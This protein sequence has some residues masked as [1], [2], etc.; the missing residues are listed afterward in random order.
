MNEKPVSDTKNLKSLGAVKTDYAKDL[1]YNPDV[2]E[3]FDAPGDNLIVKFTTNEFTSLCPRTHQPD[4][5]ANITLIYAPISHCVES[6][7]L[8]QYYMGYRNR[9]DFG[10]TIAC[11]IRDD[12]VKLL[13]P[14]WL[15]V[16]VELKPRGGIGWTSFADFGQ[17]K[18]EGVNGDQQNI[19]IL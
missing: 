8:K 3:K 7:S 14:M 15:R 10:E 19:R 5:G 1:E 16:I 17:V 2:L 9:G 18:L 12:L 4:Y 13:N 6:K 11:T